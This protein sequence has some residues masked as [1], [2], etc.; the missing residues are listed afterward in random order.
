MS[1][2]ELV[3]ATSRLYF[4]L[5]VRGSMLT[6]AVM[7]CNFVAVLVLFRLSVFLSY[8]L[9]LSSTTTNNSVTQKRSSP[10]LPLKSKRPTS[11]FCQQ[12]FKRTR[13]AA[14]SLGKKFT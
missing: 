10:Q 12:M 6:Y 3:G 11:A 9:I 5:F 14:Y 7:F 2:I 1:A 8:D 4:F 13:L